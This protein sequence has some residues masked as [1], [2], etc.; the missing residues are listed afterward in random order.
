VITVSLSHQLLI[1]L[2]HIFIQFKSYKLNIYMLY[3]ERIVINVCKVL[4]YCFMIFQAE[5]YH[6]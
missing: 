3:N 4:W 2:P 1:T 5:Y 6:V